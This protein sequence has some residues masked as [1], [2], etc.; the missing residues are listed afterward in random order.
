MKKTF[1]L[2]PLIFLLNS[3]AESVALLGTSVGA[4]SNG[5]V[6]ESS[7][8]T[9]VSYGIKKQTGKSILEHAI[10]YADEVNP[11]KKKEPCISF[12]EK[13]NSEICKIVKKQMALTKTKIIKKR[14]TDQPLDELAFTLLPIINEKS[15]I[16]YL[17]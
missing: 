15:K 10:N 14:V 12:I 3:C 17:D 2:L 16:K 8:N 1:L 9:A 13:T 7:L 5:K 6:L 11:E 4:A